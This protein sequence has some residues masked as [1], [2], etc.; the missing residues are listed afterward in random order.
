MWEIGPIVA[1]IASFIGEGEEGDVIR[2]MTNYKYKHVDKKG[3]TYCNGLLHSWNDEPAVNRAGMKGWFKDGKPHRDG[4]KPAFECTNGTKAW[5]KDC[6][7]HR[8]G[9]KPA[10]EWVH[11]AKEWYKNGKLHRD[12]G[13]PAVIC[14]SGKKEWWIDGIRMTRWTKGMV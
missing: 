8:D 2:E 6:K 3:R 14:S 12:D 10:V 1:I 4:D 11:G 13:L 7:P 9:D 5:H